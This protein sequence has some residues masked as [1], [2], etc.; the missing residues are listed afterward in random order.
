MNL[1]FI[2]Q[3]SELPRKKKLALGKKE[4]KSYKTLFN[5]ILELKCKL[6]LITNKHIVSLRLLIGVLTIYKNVS[7]QFVLIHVSSIYV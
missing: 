6:K 3:N 4:K 1:Q 2:S 5:E 7:L